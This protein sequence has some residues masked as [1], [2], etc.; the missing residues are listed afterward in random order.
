MAASRRPRLDQRQPKPRHIV[1]SDGKRVR[2]VGQSFRNSLQAQHWRDAA[3]VV[4]GP[5]CR[6]SQGSDAVDRGVPGGDRSQMRVFRTESFHAR[7][8]PNHWDDTGAVA[9]GE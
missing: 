3:P 1:A 2:S 6:P 5:P 7:I 8:L 4:D 9:T